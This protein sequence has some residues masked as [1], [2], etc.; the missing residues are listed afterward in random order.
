M[1]RLYVS[2]GIHRAIFRFG[3]IAEIRERDQGVIVDW[4]ELESGDEYC[5]RWARMLDGSS[6]NIRGMFP[7][8][9]EYKGMKYTAEH[10]DSLRIMLET[11]RALEAL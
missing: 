3:D 8:W 9:V 7:T 4:A 5:R 11:E 2:D 10:L 1:N 6:L